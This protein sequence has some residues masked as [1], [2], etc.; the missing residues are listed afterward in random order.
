MIYESPEDNFWYLI[1]TFGSLRFDQLAEFFDTVLPPETLK[2]LVKKYLF[3]HKIT[4]SQ[5][6][7]IEPVGGAHYGSKRKEAIQLAFWIVVN[8]GYEAIDEIWC[9]GYPTVICFSTN[10]GKAY[11]ISYCAEDYYALKASEHI[12]QNRA[13]MKA[14]DAGME[15]P[16]VHICLVPF[17]EYGPKYKGLGFNN[18]AIIQK[19]THLPEYFKWD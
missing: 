14:A 9:G 11:E 16:F 19:H 8:F 6:G 15:D 13:I 4:V 5:T 7:V 1:D 18:Y 10:N 2:K 3:A 17:K 12:R